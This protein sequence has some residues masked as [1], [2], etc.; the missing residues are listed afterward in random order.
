MANVWVSRRDR[1]IGSS[2]NKGTLLA[3]LSIEAL[4]RRILLV[5]CLKDHASMP[6]KIIK[7][8]MLVN[9]I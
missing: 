7:S 6:I 3:T 1:L 5:D 9:V 4:A 8:Q 2:V